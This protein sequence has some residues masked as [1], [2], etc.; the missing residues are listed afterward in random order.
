MSTSWAGPRGTAV[1]YY[2]TTTVLAVI[3][4][5]IMVNLIRPGIG[6]FLFRKK[7]SAWPRARHGAVLSS[8]ASDDQ[9][10]STQ[11]RQPVNEMVAR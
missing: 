6:I 8:D 11:F 9:T 5:L 10:H 2:L 3:V 1:A 4:G 7:I